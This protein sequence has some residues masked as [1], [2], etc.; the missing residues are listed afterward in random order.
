MGESE[1]SVG[2]ENYWGKERYSIF[3]YNFVVVK[4]III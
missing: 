2:Q 1:Y 3:L 4:T